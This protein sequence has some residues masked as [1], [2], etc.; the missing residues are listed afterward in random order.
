MSG[1][2]QIVASDAD[3]NL[4]TKT[5]AGLDLVTISDV[6]AIRSQLASLD[7]RLKELEE[8]IQ[9]LARWNAAS[10]RTSKSM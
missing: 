3:G 1:P 7:A 9:K 8:R 5:A 4:V 6:N 10:A 2:V